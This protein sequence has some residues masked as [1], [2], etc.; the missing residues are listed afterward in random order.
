M[1]R[2]GFRVYGFGLEDQNHLTR[3][4]VMGGVTGVTM[5][6]MACRIVNYLNMRGCFNY[7]TNL[8]HH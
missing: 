2:F 1:N 4:S 3:K 7:D 8:G 5:Y 6:D